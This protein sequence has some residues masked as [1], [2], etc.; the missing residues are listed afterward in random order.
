VTVDLSFAAISVTAGEVLAFAVFD[1]G[2]LTMTMS[3]GFIDIG[4]ALYLDGAAYHR[5][6]DGGPW[7]LSSSFG[8]SDAIF[9]TFVTSMQSTPPGVPSASLLELIVLAAFMAYTGWR[10]SGART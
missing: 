8:G 3:L 9:R 6:A 7:I 1:N 10:T 4:T 2:P 5:S